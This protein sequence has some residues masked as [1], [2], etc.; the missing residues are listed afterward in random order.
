MAQAVGAVTGDPMSCRVGDHD[1]TDITRWRRV[2]QWVAV[3]CFVFLGLGGSLTAQQTAGTPAHAY[4]YVEAY[5]ARFECLISMEEMLV[6][7]GQPNPGNLSADS[8]D[9]ISKL[10]RERVVGWLQVKIDGTPAAPKLLATSVVKGVPGRTEKVTEGEPLAVSDTMMGMVW[11]LPLESVPAKISVEWHGFEGP[12]KSLPVSVVLGVQG[13]ASAAAQASDSA[14]K[15]S[16]SAGEL[17]LTKEFPSRVWENVGGAILRRG[18]EPVPDLPVA[19]SVRVPLGSILWLIVGWLVFRKNRS[20]ARKIPG[21]AITKWMSL[22]LGAAV[23]WRV[24]VVEISSPTGA[25][26]SIDA[27]TAERILTSLLRNTY[28]AFDQRDESAIYDTLAKGIDGDL[29][30]KIYLQTV[31]ALTLDAQDGT[32]VSVTDVGVDVDSVAP[33]QAGQGFVARG[34]WTAIGSVGHWGHNHPRVNGYKAT[35][36]VRPV[37]GVWKITGLEILEER[38][39]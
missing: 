29:L 14:A 18:I 32:R 39:A 13:G 23:L 36:T 26:Q 8:Q 22:V 2:F 11:S 1:R 12:L 33:M 25:D 6:I 17:L 7:L 38:R 4:L 37:D 30:E 9:K 16:L 35:I 15:R 10:A 21:S 20:R 3:F 19:K 5:Q 27:K 28:R 24:G 34:G 31:K